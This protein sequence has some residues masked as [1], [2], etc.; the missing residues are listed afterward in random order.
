MDFNEI[1][2]FSEE[3]INK[4][5]EDTPTSTVNADSLDN[6]KKIPEFKA[7]DM[8][9]PNLDLDALEEEAKTEEEKKEEKPEGTE[10]VDAK[11][12][13]DKADEGSAE[14]TETTEQKVFF[15]NT[16]D[17]L[18]SQGIWKDFEG[19]EELTEIDSETYAKLV[20]AQDAERLKERFEELVDSTGDYGKAI[21]S[22]IKSGGNPEDVIDLFKEQKDLESFDVSTEQGKL[23]YIYTYYAEILGMKEDK[24]KTFITNTILKSENKEEA[25]ESELT[26]VK[27]KFKEYYKDQLDTINKR[28]EEINRENQEKQKVFVKNIKD[29]LA[30]EDLLT[31]SE[32]RLIE[33]SITEFKHKLPN[34]AI[35]NDF[36][37]KFD[38]KQKD[39]SE[40]VKLVEFILDREAYENKIAQKK[41]TKKV[42]KKWDFIKNNATLKKNVTQNPTLNE[43]KETRLDF[44]SVFKK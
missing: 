23:D 43:D 27:D 4:L 24:I 5:F 12:D 38:E 8:T 42:E 3:A 21:I 11:T 20:A 35:V 1:T 44:S 6:S 36:Y 18:V 31:D 30:K 25:L 32:R 19:R 2:T 26:E 40:Y 15:K 9:V 22:H 13:T 16:V 10:A 28:Q 17:Y 29:A 41:E 33:K 34:G 7:Q 39:P 14:V 37:V